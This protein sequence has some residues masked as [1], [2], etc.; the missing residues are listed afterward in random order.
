MAGTSCSPG[1][2][3]GSRHGLIIFTPTLVIMIC[4]NAV[5]YAAA[6]LRSGKIVSDQISRVVRGGC[7]CV[8]NVMAEMRSLHETRDLIIKALIDSWVRGQDK[9]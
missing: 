1:A 9:L 6:S 5:M 2:R 8:K 7:K 4:N 3:P